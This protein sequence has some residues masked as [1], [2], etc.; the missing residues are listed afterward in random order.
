MISTI[1]PDPGLR[2]ELAGKVLLGGH[3]FRVLRLSTAGSRSV[4]SWFA[5]TGAPSTKAELELASRLVNAGLA[6]PRPEPAALPF[7]VVIPFHGSISELEPTLEPLRQLQA[8]SITV[9]DDGNQPPIPELPGITVLRHARP[10]GPAAARNTGWR[11]IAEPGDKAADDAV[12]FIDGGV[13]TPAQGW[14]DELGG[15]FADSNVAAVAPRVASTPGPT[16][17]EQYEQQFSPLDLGP[18]ASLVGPGRRVSYVPT[19]CL[20][21]RL[22][23]MV[24]ADGF[25]ETL[26]YGEDVDL[27][28][29]LSQT[30]Q[31]RYDPSVVVHHSPRESL[32]NF[33]AQRFQYA[34]AAAAL[35]D[36]HPTASAPWRSSLVGLAGVVLFSIGRPV[37]GVL[38]GFGPVTLL[39]DQ[40]KQTATP[41]ATS[42]RLLA[43]G[44]R[45]A[46]QSFAENAG[47]SWFGL[48]A[49]A[50]LIPSFRLASL[51][52]MAAGWMRRMTMTRSPR[53][54][55][56]G[57]VDDISYGVGSIAGAIKHRSLR[58]L[59]PSISRWG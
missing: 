54:I 16:A 1:D 28:W 46:L 15:H 18:A 37:P 44:H 52:W 11:S 20:L 35:D 49:V 2:T 8:G 45:W 56:L 21:V 27:V 51:A 17:I 23:D 32:R 19:A 24:E 53:A 26:R 55:G 50:A 29:R 5:G 34:T 6:H 47:R 33:M 30:R 3:P 9:V 58:S 25:D 12:L 7:H 38:V 43:A 41:T 14:V 10:K 31:V 40:L 36:R 22:A 59:L 48:T 39:A 42:I 57:I 13:I 4:R